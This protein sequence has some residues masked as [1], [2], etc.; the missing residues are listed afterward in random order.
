MVAMR[1]VQ[2]THAPPANSAWDSNRRCSGPLQGAE[3]QS[4]DPLGASMYRYSLT[5][6]LIIAAAAF[7]AGTP[8]PAMATRYYVANGHA[9]ANDANAG[10]SPT[11][12]WRTIA[13]AN[14][15]LRAGDT[16]E[17]SAGTY[18][19]IINPAT[20]GAENARI[21]YKGAT[22][23]TVTLTGVAQCV[24]LTN[25]AY[26]TIDG[27]VCDQTLSSYVTLNNSHH[28]W[29]AN[30]RFDN[31]KNQNGWQDGILLLNNSHHNWIHDNWIG[32]VGFSTST[33]SNGGVM[34]IGNCCADGDNSHY[35]LIER[36]TLFYGGH[37]LLQ[38]KTSY[39]VIR[40]NYFHNEEWMDWPD[41]RGTKVGHRLIIIEV[42]MYRRVT[43]NTTYWTE[44]SSR[45]PVVHRTLADQ[46]LSRFGRRIISCDAM[47]FI[48]AT[49][50]V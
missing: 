45:F 46:T 9:A 47:C 43:C 11:A 17:I 10:T 5:K 44:T 32:R 29:I 41:H 40:N 3:E 13:K 31:C 36:N 22:G 42:A 48:I 25:R 27:I 26:I 38:I 39:N 8:A 2:A 6:A 34:R 35:N 20:S 4:H 15:T 24:S 14:A 30:S 1:R 23:Q 37:H 33:T 50:P 12:P 49:C 28:I 21:T 18:V 7:I 16:L 19:E